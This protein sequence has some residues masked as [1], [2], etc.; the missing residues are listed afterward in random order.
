MG[1]SYK[2]GPKFNERPATERAFSVSAAWRSGLS[3]VAHNHQ[4]VRSNRTAAT[5][6][7][8]TAG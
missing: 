6:L 2:H 5:T 8:Q 3:R 7:R 1:R 4:I